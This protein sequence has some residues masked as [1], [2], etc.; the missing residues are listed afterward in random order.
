VASIRLRIVTY[1]IQVLAQGDSGV[2]DTLARLS[3]DLVGLQEVD[4][5]TTRSQ[6]RSQAKVLAEALGMQYAYAAAMPYAGGEFG[7][8]ILSRGAIT[9]VRIERLPRGGQE[10]PR[11]AML[12]TCHL[13]DGLTL[14]FANTHLAS[15]W[16]TQNPQHVR[17][18][19]AAALAQ[20]L[21]AEA[22]TLPT[23]LFLVGD[24]N[25][26]SATEAIAN[27]RSVARPLHVDLPT[28]P[29]TAPAEAL[30]HVYYVPVAA[31][32]RYLVEV[33]S[34]QSEPSTASDHLPLCVEVELTEPAAGPR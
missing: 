18:L 8:A 2:I 17:A 23:P 20:V 12:A 21:K 22:A 13:A 31:S 30:D 3:P 14:R 26:D 10:E 16:H 5:G 7:I 29:A 15:D 27:L 19:Q 6:G 25:A 34:A 32:D 9:D 4:Q 11:V 24:F 28:Y 33:L 1:N